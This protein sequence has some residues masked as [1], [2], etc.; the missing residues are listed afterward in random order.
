MGLIINV[1]S[2]ENYD[3]QALIEQLK[4]YAQ[5]DRVTYMGYE[6]HKQGDA[7]IFVGTYSSPPDQAMFRIKGNTIWVSNFGSLLVKRALYAQ[8]IIFSDITRL[9]ETPEDARKAYDEF[10]PS[11]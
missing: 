3:E 11:A 1:L 7:Y 10:D 8:D 9:F 6:L 4:K 2:C 5:R